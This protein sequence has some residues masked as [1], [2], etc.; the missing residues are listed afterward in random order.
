[1]K[2]R[3]IFESDFDPK[4]PLKIDKITIKWDYDE[5]PD[6]FYLQQEYEDCEPEEREKY[7]KQDA[8]RL[9]RLNL[10]CWSFMS[11]KAEAELS[12]P[13]GFRCRRIFELTS[14]GLHGIES[15][16]GADYLKSIELDELH[17]LAD[18][19]KTLV[20]HVSNLGDVSHDI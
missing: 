5:Y 7:K 13:T 4:T 11:C 14:G 2:T 17:N 16:S 19:I 1:M 12:Y 6:I 9:K 10:G 18:H 3:T 20:P 8:L 15:D